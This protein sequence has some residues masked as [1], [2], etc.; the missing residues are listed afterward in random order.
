MTSIRSFAQC[1]AVCLLILSSGCNKPAI[2][3]AQSGGRLDSN[4]DTT[5]APSNIVKVLNRVKC[6]ERYTYCSQE[7]INIIWNTCLEN[8]Y[9]EAAP[10]GSIRS[11]RD[12]VELVAKTKVVPERRLI[13]KEVVDGNGIVTTENEYVDATSE[14]TQ[15]GYCM[16]SEYIL[17]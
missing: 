11:S 3:R 5:P 16:G 15:K 7:I 17:E 10:S 12:I 13:Q 8:G 9:Q 1:A 2:N 6:H 14:V 4:R